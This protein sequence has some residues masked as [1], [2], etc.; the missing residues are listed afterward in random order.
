[1]PC[2]PQILAQRVVSISRILDEHAQDRHTAVDHR[3]QNNQE[4]A[5]FS[6]R[7][8]A[9]RIT[10]SGEVD[11]PRPNFLRTSRRRFL[12][13]SG[14]ACDRQ[15]TIASGRTSTA[16]SSSTPYAFRHRSL[17]SFGLPLA[18]SL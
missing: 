3:G 5:R 17:V 4:D 6:P 11:P 2:P 10:S 9:H 8:R 12:L 16:P 18:P 14:P 15:A 7:L 13:P 1:M